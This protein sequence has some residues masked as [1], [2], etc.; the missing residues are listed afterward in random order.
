MVGSRHAPGRPPHGSVVDARVAACADPLHNPLA[1]GYARL[2]GGRIVPA[3][4]RDV[5]MALTAHHVTL[6]DVNHH[7]YSYISP[8]SSLALPN[9]RMGA[10][11]TTAKWPAAS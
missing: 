7:R 2:A 5:L 4:A 8:S 1:S 10:R 3:D 6:R 11:S 9:S